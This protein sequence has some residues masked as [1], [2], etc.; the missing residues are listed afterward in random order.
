MLRTDG[1]ANAAAAPRRVRSRGA[2]I[3]SAS[4][5]LGLGFPAEAAGETTTSE[6]AGWTAIAEQGA[7]WEAAE[8]EEDTQAKVAEE[9]RW[10]VFPAVESDVRE[11]LGDAAKFRYCHEEGYRLWPHE[12]DTYCQDA[13]VLAERCQGLARACQLPAFQLMEREEVEVGGSWLHGMGEV[14]RVLFWL[15]LALGVGLLLRALARNLAAEVQRRRQAGGEPAP[16]LIDWAPEVPPPP[17]ETDAERLLAWAREQAAR[18]DFGAALGSAY[19]AALWT[20][21]QRGLIELHRSRTNG[22][23]LRQLAPHPTERDELRHIVRDVEAVQFG[24]APADRARFD[25]L[26]AQV[27]SLVQRASLWLALAL[28]PFTGTACSAA[29]Q[30]APP[31]AQHGPDGYALFETLLQRHSDGAQRRVRRL[32]GSLDEVTTFVALGPALRQEEWD[33]LMA[34]VDR[35][36]TLVTAGVPPP[37]R[38][39]VPHDIDDLRCEAPLTLSARASDDALT[40]VQAGAHTFRDFPSAEP[41]VS[42]GANPFLVS[43]EH[44]DGSVYLLADDAWLRNANL[45]AA[46]NAQVIVQLAAAPGGRVELLGPWTGSGAHHPLESIHKAGLTPWLLQLALL[47]LAYAF[48]RGV[49]F[50]TPREPQ[51]EQRRSFTE[52]A[53]ALGNQYAR[54]QASGHA[55]EQYGRWALE[56]IRERV[57]VRERDLHALSHA[58]AR[59]TGGDPMAILRILVEAQSAGQIQGSP[60]EH[61]RT[62]ESLSRI[63]R[64]V[65]GA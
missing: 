44:G 29:S 10:I 39:Y 5:V 23:Y 15:T 45:G 2:L 37:L 36:G 60:E 1:A 64:D 12:K 17:R 20:L 52:H 47:G 54:R 32:T 27:T 43:L 50:G 18:G 26:L 62:M 65:G 48:A 56:R 16:E 38:K 41:L 14:V 51:R 6:D 13:D 25:R 28:L 49:R 61:S 35:G 24:H 59:R 34:W 22:D 8:E 4:L 9:A 19:A 58:V 3:A 11:V 63:L 33:L 46:D 42:C 30:P 55:L 40:L 7:T 31:H 53:Q 21:N 57:P